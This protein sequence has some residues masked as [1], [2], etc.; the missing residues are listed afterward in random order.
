MMYQTDGMVAS[1]CGS[2]ASNGLPVS[3]CDPATTQLLLPIPGTDA[4]AP[5]QAGDISRST[6]PVPTTLGTM[7]GASAG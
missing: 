4:V 7:I 1:R 6:A 2:F 3:V 5:G